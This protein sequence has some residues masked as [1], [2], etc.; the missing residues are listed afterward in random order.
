MANH[1]DPEYIRQ[2]KQQQEE[3]ERQERERQGKVQQ[4]KTAPQ[5]PKVSKSVSKAG[6]SLRHFL[7]GEFLRR[8]RLWENMPYLLML[9]VMIIILIYINLLAASNQVRL[10]Q[11][12]AERI[13]LN[14]KYIQIMEQYGWLQLDQDRKEALIEVYRNR[15]F[16]DDS[17]LVY[18]LPAVGKEVAR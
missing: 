8:L 1:F 11:L 2:Q 10:E 16:V 3:K 9:F 6:L 12:E 7:G 15:G 14:D 13:E 4:D 18:M 5:K 17:S